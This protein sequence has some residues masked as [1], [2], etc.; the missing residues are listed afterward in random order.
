M[1]TGRPENKFVVIYSEEPVPEVIE[2]LKATH[3]D[4]YEILPNA[5]YLVRDKRLTV[6]V[7]VDAGFKGTRTRSHDAHGLVVKL[8]PHLSGYTDPAVWKWFSDE[9]SEP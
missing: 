9:Q 3:P 1:K 2:R 8:T 7:S 6:D 4:H 5:V